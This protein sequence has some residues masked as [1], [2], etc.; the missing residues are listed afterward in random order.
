[1]PDSHRNQ[2]SKRKIQNDYKTK[3]KK[4]KNFTSLNFKCLILGTLQSIP[5]ISE[6]KFFYARATLQRTK[7]LSKIPRTHILAHGSRGSY[8]Y[9]QEERHNKYCT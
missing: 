6:I 3:L 9:F 1:M 4:K 7:A 2:K 5:S 8:I